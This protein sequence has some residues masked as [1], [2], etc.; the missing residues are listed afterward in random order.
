MLPQGEEGKP[1]V[2]PYNQADLN[3]SWFGAMSVLMALL[4]R[5]K[6]GAGQYIDVAFT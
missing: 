2:P 3:A 4:R 5:E 1:F 6:D